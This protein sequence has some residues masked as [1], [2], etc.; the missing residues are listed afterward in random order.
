MS[1][2]LATAM[3]LGLLLGSVFVPAAVAL[4]ED[5]SGDEPPSKAVRAETTAPT[6][7]QVGPYSDVDP[8]SYAAQPIFSLAARD[9]FDGT[10]CDPASFCPSQSLP[11]WVM[12]VWVVRIVDGQD[13]P[14]QQ[15][16]FVDIAGDPWWEGHVERF[17][18]LGITAGCAVNPA[19]YCPD[20]R[21]SRE[22]MAAFLTAAF[23]LS[24]GPAAGFVDVAAD[25]IFNRAIDSL[26][27]SG[28]TAGCALD[29][30][31]Y[32][33]RNDVSR[34]QMATFLYRAIGLN[35]QPATGPPSAVVESSAPLVVDGRFEVAIRFSAPVTGFEAA[36]IAVVNG[37]ATSVT[38]NGARYTATIEPAA[39][40]TVMVRL[41]AEAARGGDGSP[42]DA[43]APFIRV[44]APTATVAPTGID[45]W[46]RPLVQQSADLELSR[47]EPPWEYT[48]NVDDC[49]AGSTSREFRES[50]IQRANWYRQMAGLGPVEESPALSADAQQ[51]ALMMLAQYALSHTPDTG[52]KCYSPAGAASAGRSNLGLG[53][54]GAAGIDAYMRDSGDNNRRVGHRRWILYPQTLEMGTGDARKPQRHFD[55]TANA[56]DVI[57]G[58]RLANRPSVREERGFVAWPPS[59]YVPAGVVWGRWSF[60]LPEADF[61][62]ASVAVAD[63]SGAVAV[64]ILDRDSRVGEPAIVWAVAGDTDSRLLPAPADGDHCYT[65]T[66]S[67]ARVGGEI[68][69]PFE[70]PVCVIDPDAATGPSV[71]L[72][73]DAPDTVGG[74]FDVTVTFSEPVNGFTS[75]DL[76]VANGAV[77]ELSGR[78]RHYDATIRPDDNGAVTVTVGAGA[79]HD[80]ASL[81]NTAAIP[82]RR[83]ASVGR[84]TAGV[85]SSAGA[86]VRGAFEVSITFSEAVTGFST[87]DVRVVNGT[88]SNLTGNGASYRATVTPSNDGTVMVR[89]LQDA[90]VAGSGRANQASAPLTRT[91]LAASSGN[92]PGIDTWDRAAVQ[93]SHA[94]EFERIEPDWDYTGDVDGCVAG[95]TSQ[96]FRDSVLG[97]VNWY[98][99]MA[100]LGRVAERLAYTSA[101]QQAA[102]IQLANGTFSISSASRC[103]TTEGAGAAGEGPGWL[104]VAGTAAI[105]AYMGQGDQLGAQRTGMLSPYL[106]EVGIG[107]A[108]D[109]DSIYRVGHK[110][111]IRYD[112]PWGARR[113]AVREAR[114]FVAWPPP[115]Y[116][117]PEMLPQRWSFMLAQADFSRATVSVADH[118]GPVPVAVAGTDSWYREQVIWWSDAEV[119]GSTRRLGPTGAD[120]C[121]TVTIS[122]V[123]VNGR[124]QSPYEYAVC[125]LYRDP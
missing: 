108:R 54:A 99:T 43:S 33:P 14:Q 59:G 13:P 92:A 36:D 113:P 84:P 101:A 39:S 49:V 30:P 89:V 10:E 91:Q 98:R 24:D 96:E 1:L 23:D 81:P 76:F 110:L 74:S 72:S 112:D 125:V 47:A 57:G 52:W 46:I 117:P 63:D 62:N 66:V 60:S 115:G 3:V 86:T 34:E 103:Y 40:G 42:S 118:S 28:I 9:V 41:P 104:G 120:H 93:A 15:S 16:R 27:H 4:T 116:V 88:V 2:R 106:A 80:S 45:T 114:G 25:G 32:C 29:P 19:R 64:E 121:Y 31:R 65:V 5:D 111:Y 67:G 79:I 7:A 73:S 37:R 38:G 20:G 119:G 83:T 95:T 109:P 17:A 94:T 51:A 21:V 107:H 26:A 18:E 105:D 90:A 44:S 6:S 87:S 50:V 123:R 102:L 35:S 75:E 58:E 124:T 77:T 11:R 82:L 68:P 56:L 61:S 97:R 8:D 100:G 53:N 70:Y 122:G 55:S 71:T 48:G 85:A 12:A 22:Q 69:T 78:G